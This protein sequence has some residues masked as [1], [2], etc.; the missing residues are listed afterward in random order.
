MSTAE[1]LEHLKKLAPA[2]RLAVIE[3]ALQQLRE[4]LQYATPEL[5][6][7]DKKEQ[8][9]SAAAALFSDYAEDG[10]LTAF[11]ILDGEDFHA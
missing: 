2:E 10:E 9:A 8:L 3:V 5:L 6:K 4:D 11:T 1:I 7:A